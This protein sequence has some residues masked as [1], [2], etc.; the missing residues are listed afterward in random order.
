MHSRH[1]VSSLSVA[2]PGTTPINPL[3]K[4]TTLPWPLSSRAIADRRWAFIGASDCL[5]RI[6]EVTRLDSRPPSLLAYLALPL[7]TNPNALLLG[8]QVNP[9]IN[10]PPRLP[11]K[12]M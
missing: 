3:R 5:A 12:G 10:V 1:L 8:P 2:C 4:G 11:P 7:P 9:L 6:R